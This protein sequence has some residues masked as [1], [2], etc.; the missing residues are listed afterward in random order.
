MV[1]LAF[2]GS[3]S[4]GCGLRELARG[5]VQPPRVAFQGLKIYPPRGGGWPLKAVLLLTN[6]NPQAID[7]VGYDYE[8]RLEGE[9]VAQGASE[10]PVHLPAGGQ[11]IAALPIWVKLPALPRLWPRLLSP[12]QRLHYQV[13]GGFRLASVLGGMLRVP[14]QFQGEFTPQ[15]AGEA[16]RPY[17]R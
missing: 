14:F 6:P 1:A 10:E 17:L 7:L 11:T 4:L 8:L 3:V 13:T 5:E 2:S 9:P 16:L 15:E 12:D